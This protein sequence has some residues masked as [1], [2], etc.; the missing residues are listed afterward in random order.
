MVRGF[1]LSCVFLPITIMSLSGLSGRDAGQAAGLTGMIR[2]LGG[3]FGVALAGTYLERA[4]AQNRAALL[5][6]LSLY[7]A[8]TVQRLQGLTAS[9]MAKGSDMVLAQSQALRVLEGML[10]KQTALITYAQTFT[11][12]GLFFLICV[13]LVLFIKPAKPGQTVDLNAAH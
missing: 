4:T 5:P 7:D 1:A 9:F 10:I 8:Q 3:S 12:I 2:Q 11:L 13:P 6:H